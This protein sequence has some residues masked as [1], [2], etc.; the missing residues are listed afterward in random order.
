VTDTQEIELLLDGEAEESRMQ[1]LAGGD[2]AVVEFRGISVTD[3]GSLG[4]T[5]ASE[6]DGATST[7]DV[8]SPAFFE[9]GNLSPTRT[10][11]ERGDE[12]TVTANV[13]NTGEVGATE[14]VGMYLNGTEVG[15]ETV[16]L[17]PG[18]SENVSFDIT[19]PM[20]TGEHSYGIRTADT[21]STG[22]L[23]SEERLLES[24]TL[25]VSDEIW[26]AVT[27][28]DGDAGNLSLADLGDVISAYQ[29]EP[30]DAEVDG[31]DIG[32]AD[33]GNLIRYYRNEVS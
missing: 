12:V 15:N 26:T 24:P 19:A 29:A 11:A 5:F 2:T 4:I 18:D 32:L 1:S 23:I 7:V 9:V 30:E 14:A 10:T 16:S 20:E 8:L 25:D 3:S 31:A 33:I 22:T 17:P 21:E 6:D 28:Q 27:A 13:T